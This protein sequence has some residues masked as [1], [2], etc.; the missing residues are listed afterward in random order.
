MRKN[1]YIADGTYDL[2][3]DGIKGQ[4]Q[5]PMFREIWEQVKKEA[6]A[7]TPSHMSTHASCWMTRTRASTTL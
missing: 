4:F 2:W 1:G 3:A 6:E 5:Q 7:I